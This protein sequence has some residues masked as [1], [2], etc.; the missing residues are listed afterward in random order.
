[1]RIDLAAD[2]DAIGGAEVMVLLTAQAASDLGH[3]VVV[4]TPTETGEVAREADQRGLVVRGVGAR[5]SNHY[6]SRLRHGLRRSEADVL[7]CHGL[8]PSVATAGLP[9]R[10]V[11]LHQRPRWSQRGALRRAT[12]GSLGVLVPS[13][14]MASDIPGAQVMWNWC[15]PKTADRPELGSTLR[16][17]FLGR[18][19]L[20]KGI[21]VLTE[22][23]ADLPH[24]QLVLAGT[25][26]FVVAS[27]RRP[28]ER[29]LER[30]AD[31][32][33]R[34]G[35][36]SAAELFGRIDV[37]AVPPVWPEPFG[38][39]V[40]EAMSAGVPLIVSDAGA[41]REVAG[42][43]Y[44]LC[45]RAGDSRALAAALHTVSAMSPVQRAELT[46][47]L[48]A[49]WAENFSPSVGRAR[50]NALLEGI[51]AGLAG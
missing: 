7:W 33:E 44:P 21:G 35:W 47:A 15:D 50:V 13:S 10:L 9:N 20:A 42:E 39:V 16:V 34:L 36:V 14:D 31:R 18:I 51:D 41:L 29:A 19:S 24:T 6:M 27:E 32:T 45:V 43:N 26:R 2:H 23:L 4:W 22:A 37:L 40:I 46:S 25:P 11:H 17:G 28:T 48:H 30:V 8:R 5:S 1:M 12:R 38:L 3:E 49:R